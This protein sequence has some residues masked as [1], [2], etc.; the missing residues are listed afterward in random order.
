MNLDFFKH[1][2]VKSD[3][4]SR[5][6]LETLDALMRVSL[7]SLLMENMDWAIKNWHLEIDQ[8]PEGFA[9]GVGWW[10]SAL[11]WKSSNFGAPFY[12]M[13]F[14]NI[15]RHHIIFIINTKRPISSF[16]VKCCKKGWKFEWSVI[17]LKPFTLKCMCTLQTWILRGRKLIEKDW[18]VK[19]KIQVDTTGKKFKILDFF[20]FD[21]L[22][23]W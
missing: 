20:P 18:W 23:G 7:C 4:R 6:K 10:L 2:W 3:R 13:C 15:M 11:C 1:N 21:L 9:F 19:L 5:L 14:L 22:V 8:K 17:V 12:C 16:L